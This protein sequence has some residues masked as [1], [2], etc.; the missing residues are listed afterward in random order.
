MG[1]IVSTIQNPNNFSDFNSSSGY[2]MGV[3]WFQQSGEGLYCFPIDLA[4]ANIAGVKDGANVTIQIV[5][6][7]GDGL[8]YQVGKAP[9]YNY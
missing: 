9:S 4:T 8:L 3:Q 7:G 2:Q 5:F 6:D 1:V